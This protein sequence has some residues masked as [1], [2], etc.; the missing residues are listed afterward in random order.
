MS[1]VGIK[2]ADRGGRPIHF[3]EARAYDGPM[4]RIAKVVVRLPLN[5]VFDYTIP[6]ELAPLAV[7]GTP[8]VVPFGRS[9]RPGYIVEITDHSDRT[10]L[11]PILQI[12]GRQALIREPVMRLARWMADYYLAPLEAAVHTVLPAPVRHGGARELARRRV[13]LEHWPPPEQEARLQRRAP[14]QF[15]VLSALRS[16]HGEQWLANL[17]RAIQG[18]AAAVRALAAAGWVRVETATRRRAP[19]HEDR[20][21]R[22]APLPLMPQQ[23]AAL[24]TIRRA[25]DTRRP[26]VVLLFGVTGSGKTEVYLQAMDH[27]L[28]NDRG[29]IVLVP[30]ISLT[31]QTVERFRARFGD[32]IAVLHSHLSD[33]ERFDEWYRVYEG[34][35][36]IV[37]G[38]RSA[39]FA[40][41]RNLGLIV[42]DEEHEPTYKQDETPRYHARDVAVMRGHLEGCAVVLGSATPSLESWRNAAIGKYALVE[43]PH[44]V[45]HRQMPAIRI[46]DMRAESARTGRAAVFSKIL[47]E[48]IEDRLAKGEQT[49]LFLNRRGYAS[50]LICPR[51]GHVVRCEACSVAMVFHKVRAQLVCHLCG[52][53][54]P[55]P[56]R[57]PAKDC[58]DPA[59]R[60]AGVGTERVEEILKRLFPRARVARMDSDTM[61]RKDDYRRVLGEFRLGRLD[62]LIGTQMIAKG[63]DFPNVTLVGVVQA[64][65]ALHLPDFRAGERTFQLLIQVAG[66]AGRGDVA[67]EVVVQTYTP[68]HAAV[69]AARR[70][71]WATFYDQELAFRRELGYPPF[72]HV[73]LLLLRGESE[74]AVAAAAADAAASLRAQL[75]ARAVVPDPAPAPIAKVR[76]RYRYQILMRTTKVLEVLELLRR[77]IR[78]H[79][80][81]SGV[82]GVFDVDAVSIL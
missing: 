27:A 56:E 52:A 78:E 39:L 37:V 76:G 54:G 61:A 57:C 53:A 10:D 51:C 13:V 3:G 26:P 17:A 43:M 75:G 80:W 68:F 79:P 81:P 74:V 66:R 63:L 49:I 33:G 73:I 7:P 2:R 67:G 9:R 18:A 19:A 65:L 34:R 20:T 62:V 14:R 47:I 31:P 25:I 82:E 42:V 38:A 5:R 59:I 71:D 1:G 35:A 36:R 22:T 64:D 24:E 60:H 41:V 48:R 8:V 23:V 32:T 16:A 4:P 40:P 46:V 29:A 45:D 50:S 28:R 55:V 58:G 6:D 77:W 30:E 44:R 21:V 70:L 15:A 12:A 11:K 69:Q 72:A